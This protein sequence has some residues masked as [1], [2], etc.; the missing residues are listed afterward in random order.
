MSSTPQNPK[1]KRNSNAYLKYSGMVG[2]L[3][4][5]LFAAAFLGQWLDEKMNNE[6]PLVTAGL[7]ILALLA[8]LFKLSIDLKRD[9]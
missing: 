1:K 5:L 9:S 6:K 4:I 3:L 2:Q 8:Y 7:L